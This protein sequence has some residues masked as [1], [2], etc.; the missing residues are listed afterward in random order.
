MQLTSQ[1][2]DMDRATAVLQELTATTLEDLARQGY[3]DDLTVQRAV[4][5][6]YFGQN[7]ELEVPVAFDRFDDATTAA[8]WQ[9]FHDM[10][11]ARFGFNMPASVIEVVNFMT[12]AVSATAKPALPEL[13]RADGSLAP[14]GHRF[15]VYDDGTHETPV[16]ARADLRR[17]HRLTGPA[18]VEEAASV[19][20]LQPGQTL[21]VDRFV[22]LLIK[23]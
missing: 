23:G 8:T 13:P 18:V 20:V 15:V 1:S 14:R 21:K 5:M 2:F 11:L 16:F 9:E 10:H 4:E 3:R 17:G 19:T 22:N 7:Y 12:T 6:R